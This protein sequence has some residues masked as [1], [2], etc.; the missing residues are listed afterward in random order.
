MKYFYFLGYNFL[1][2]IYNSTYT[3]FPFKLLIIDI[4]IGRP[5]VEV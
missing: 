4:S 3:S 5:F 1:M 2:Y